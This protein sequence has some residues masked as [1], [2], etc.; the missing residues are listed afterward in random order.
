[1]PAL[2]DLL[3]K[4]KH[5]HTNAEL[6]SIVGRANAKGAIERYREGSVFNWRLG[7]ALR[8]DDKEIEALL[9]DVN[10]RY[11]TKYTKTDLLPDGASTPISEGKK[12]ERKINPKLGDESGKLSSGISKPGKADISGGRGWELNQF[13]ND[14][15]EAIRKSGRERIVSQ[16]VRKAVEDGTAKLSSGV[17]KSSP[18]TSRQKTE[19]TGWAR[20]QAWS[21]FAK[22]LINQI[23]AGK[24]LSPAQWN[25][26]MQLHD[27][28]VRRR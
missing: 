27:A 10:K 15:E 28:S 18:V 5:A 26:L 17:Q 21:G 16:R 13:A 14:M 2:K 1:L 7:K 22:S 23:D 8:Y 9:A 12:V 19:L 4:N 6:D 25:R 24:E 11:G 3:E 20:N